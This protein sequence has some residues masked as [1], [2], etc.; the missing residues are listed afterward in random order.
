MVNFAQETRI[1]VRFGLLRFLSRILAKARAARWREG[2]G[3]VWG[4]AEPI[5]P[6]AFPY[7]LTFQFL[8]F[9][10]SLFAVLSRG[11]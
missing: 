6:F 8:H 2:I 4:G 10:S 9:R 3:C 11:M 1:A 7:I 5:P